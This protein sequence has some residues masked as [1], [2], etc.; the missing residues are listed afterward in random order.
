M[1]AEKM[2]IASTDSVI[3]SALDCRKMLAMPAT[4]SMI[5]PMKSHLPIALRSRLMTDDRRRHAEED[6]AG[7][8]EGRHDQA[9][10]VGQAEHACRP[11]ATASGP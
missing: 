11:G 10:A 3:I 2:P 1:K 4:S 6:G 9:G 7:A 8:G 5:A